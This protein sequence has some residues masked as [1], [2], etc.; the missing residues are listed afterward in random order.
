MKGNVVMIRKMGQ[1]DVSQRTKDGMFNATS[2]LKQA[3]SAGITKKKMDNFFSKK[4]TA[5]FVS[6]LE[7]RETANNIKNLNTPHLGYLKT[8][9]KNGGTW[10]H[11]MLFIDFAMYISP[12]FKYDVL[13]FVYDQLLEYRN[14]AGDNYKGLTSAVQRFDNINYPQLAKGLNYIVFGRHEKNI[15]NQATQE[16][17]ESLKSLQQKLA[18]ACDMGYINSFE[19]LVEEMRRLY[20]IKTI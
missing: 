1:F 16:E 3:A 12:S 13:K 17:L 18:F 9:G 7:K 19:K 11:P 8:R 14:D 10:M 20:S 15:R 2:L 4:E 6:E 5:E